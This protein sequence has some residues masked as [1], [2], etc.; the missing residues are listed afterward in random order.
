MNRSDY[1]D[2]WNFDK[3]WYMGENNIP[4]LKPRFTVTFISDQPSLFSIGYYKEPDEGSYTVENSN[5]KFRVLLAPS[6]S[7]SILKITDTVTGDTIFHENKEFLITMEMGND[8]VPIDFI[9]D[10][11]VSVNRYKVTVV[12]S[13]LP[14]G[15]TASLPP[16][17]EHG[18]EVEICFD[19]ESYDLSKLDLNIYGGHSRVIYKGY[20]VYSVSGITDDLYIVVSG[21]SDRGDLTIAFIALSAACI[22]VT[23]GIIGGVLRLIKKR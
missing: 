8:Y 13:S 11:S 7:R 21:F 16:D 23:V 22:I 14:E 2:N 5:E 3:I 6:S 12:S 20:G 9:I 4:V 15:V 18:K 17:V 1:G 10:V 19:S